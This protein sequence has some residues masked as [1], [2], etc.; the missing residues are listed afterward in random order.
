MHRPYRIPIPDWA[1]P[2]VVLPPT[3]GVL[4]I[5]AL[6]NW[7]VYI[8]CAGAL[9][10]GVVVFKLSE[11]CKRR[12]WLEF[13]TKSNFKYDVAPIGSPR[14]HENGDTQYH[15]D[16]TEDEDDETE[17]PNEDKTPMKIV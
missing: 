16:E 6:S 13:E 5:F 4:L 14:L 9:I 10:F 11:L 1:A 7:F 15:D 17:I 8:F 3:L 2:L 12:G